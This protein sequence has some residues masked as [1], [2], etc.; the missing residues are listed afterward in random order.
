MNEFFKSALSTLGGLMDHPAF[1][2]VAVLLLLSAY[3]NTPHFKGWHGES[4][5]RSELKRGL[6]DKLYTSLHNLLIP[7]G[8][9]G[10]SQIDHLVVSRFGLFVIET[11]HYSGWIS[12]KPQAKHWKVAYNKHSQHYFLNP[13]LQNN[14]H[15]KAVRHVLGVP[16]HH[17]C[18]VVVFSGS[19]TLKSPP[20]PGV[21]V[22]RLFTNVLANYIKSF[23]ADLMLPGIPAQLA[24][25]LRRS[26]LSHDPA[27]RKA[28]LAAVK[29]EQMKG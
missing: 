6:P 28:H 22:C 9:G 13:V 26:D 16:E 15:I 8:E 25:Q 24:A 10:H 18:N 7:D 5:V 14:G 3:T 2:I 19:A 17:C 23:P 11:K 12:G 1:W 21:L 20:I 27:A 4:I 29:A